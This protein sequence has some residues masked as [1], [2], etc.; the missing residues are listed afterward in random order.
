M[1]KINRKST[2]VI[3]RLLEQEK[4]KISE[5]IINI[6]KSWWDNQEIDLKTMYDYRND[7][8]VA[9]CNFNNLIK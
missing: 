9:S 4:K 1:E 3:L 5:T 6:M 2:K 7:I 8:S